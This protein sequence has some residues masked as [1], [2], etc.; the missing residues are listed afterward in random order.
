MYLISFL[1]SY[2]ARTYPKTAS[3]DYPPL[4]RDVAYVCIYQT[5]AWVDPSIKYAVLLLNSPDRLVP[6]AYLLGRSVTRSG[7]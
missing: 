3:V 6:Y 7:F 1:L 2:Q 4:N 5:K